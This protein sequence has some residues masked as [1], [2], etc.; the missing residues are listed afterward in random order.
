MQYGSRADEATPDVVARVTLTPTQLIVECESRGHLDYL[1]HLLAST[2]GYS[3]HCRGESMVLPSHEMPSVDLQRDR[4]PHPSVV[5][6]PEEEH[7]LLA[8]FLES[9]YSGLT[10]LRQR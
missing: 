6:T 7:R 10:F 4:L 9:I 3:L 2:F 1:K 5:V 8:A